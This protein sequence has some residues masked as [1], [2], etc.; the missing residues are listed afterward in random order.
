MRKLLNS[1]GTPVNFGP[2]ANYIIIPNIDFTLPIEHSIH[3][4]QFITRGMLVSFIGCPCLLYLWGCDELQLKYKLSPQA[5]AIYKVNPNI[6]MWVS[7]FQ[8]YIRNHN[9]YLLTNK[10]EG[11]RTPPNVRVY[12]GSKNKRNK[13]NQKSKRKYKNNNNKTKSR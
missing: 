2:I 10:N 12:G 7:E 4:N 3:I 5:E 8:P 9:S 11:Y 1:L 6:D 13:K